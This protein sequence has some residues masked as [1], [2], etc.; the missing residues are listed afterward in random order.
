[1][2]AL[3]VRAEDAGRSG[4]KDSFDAALARAVGSLPEV[5][6]YTFPLLKEG[7]YALLQRGGHAP[8]EKTRALAAA[9]ELGGELIRILE[10]KPFPEA[11]NL[12]VWIFQKTSKTPLRFPR[13]PGMAKKRPLGSDT[14]SH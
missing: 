3:P 6:E 8:G 14:R 2:T 12:Y 10:A 9:G 1:M 7:G 5:L 4:L 13:R 11:R